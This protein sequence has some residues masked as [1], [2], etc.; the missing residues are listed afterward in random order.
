MS[1]ARIRPGE[2]VGHAEITELF[3]ALSQPVTTVCCALAV[4]AKKA[5]GREL[6]GDLQIARE[7]AERVAKL[8]AVLRERVEECLA[9]SK[10]PGAHAANFP[11]QDFPISLA[12]PETG[13]N[14]PL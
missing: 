14:L 7:H 11:R 4:S 13:N 1:E 12:S 5:R 9:E 2:R 6:R 3:H 8:I 10:V